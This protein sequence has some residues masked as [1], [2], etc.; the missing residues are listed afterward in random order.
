M[1]AAVWYT[2]ATLVALT[3]M[4]SAS[5]YGDSPRPGAGAWTIHATS[6]LVCMLILG[7]TLWLRDT[8]TERHRISEQILS[9]S[10][11]QRWM[12]EQDRRYQLEDRQHAKEEREEH[13]HDG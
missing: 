8:D 5:M 13:H 9:D 6:M 12:R 2:M 1:K 7:V 4:L 3:M 11:D 10:N